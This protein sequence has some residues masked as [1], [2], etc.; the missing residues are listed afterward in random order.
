MEK[1][2]KSPK[3]LIS[4]VKSMIVDKEFINQKSKETI[5][6]MIQSLKFKNSN[7]D[8]IHIEIDQM[9]PYQNSVSK[10]EY[11]FVEDI[12][13]KLGIDCEEKCRIEITTDIEE[14]TRLILFISRSKPRTL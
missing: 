7:L 11:R 2:N 5:P 6:P 14:L 3:S 4:I 13:S 9:I 12:L 8:S 1:S 10:M